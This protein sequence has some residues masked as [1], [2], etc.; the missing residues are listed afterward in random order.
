MVKALAG[1]LVVLTVPSL[2]GDTWQICVE[3]GSS[4]LTSPVRGAVVREIRLLMGRQVARI[5]F[6]GC[7]PDVPIM[8]L[9]ISAEAP[10]GLEGVLGLAYRRS[11]RVQPILK[12]F[13]GPLVRYIGEPN[14]ASAI[15]RALARVAAHEASHFLGQQTHHCRIGLMRAVLPPFELAAK[16]RWPFRRT[17]RCRA[18]D[19]TVAR[20]LHSTE[21][22]TMAHGGFG[23]Q[24]LASGPGES[25]IR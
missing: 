14:N 23:S 22:R 9:T 19:R 12:V 20:D 8:R 6:D 3:D 1:L 25:S 24:R 13:H 11:D 7:A 16:D 17:S 21:A 4:L 5:E 18:D 10:D 15:G 2:A